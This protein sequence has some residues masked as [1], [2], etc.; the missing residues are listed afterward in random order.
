MKS[1]LFSRRAACLAAAL[2]VASA[3]LAG[4]GSSKVPAP[5][6]AHVEAVTLPDLADDRAP[7]AVD[8]Y[9]DRLDA[10]FANNQPTPAEQFTYTI[11]DGAVTITAYTG[12]DT[13]V[14][15]PETVE[16]LPVVAIAEHAFAGKGEVRGVSI[17]DSVME[18]EPGALSGCVGLTTLRTPLATASGMIHFGSLFG[19]ETYETNAAHVPA[20]LATLILTRGDEIPAYAFYDCNP[21][22]IFLPD[23]V[24][25]IGDFAFYGN[26][27]LVH[28][29][30]GETALISVGEHAFTNC[31]AL[32]SLELP[33]SVDVMGFAMLEGCGKLESL[34][35]PFVGARRGMADLPEIED[36]EDDGDGAD[37]E[38][39]LTA[40]HLGYL[41]G[42]RAYV[43][44]AGYIPASLIT[45]TVHE[46]CGEIADNAFFECASIREVILPAGVTAIGRRAFYGCSKI[47]RMI[48][49]DSVTTLGDDA[50]HGCIRL[51]ELT[52]GAGVTTL[53]VQVFMDCLSLGHVTLPASVTHLPNATFAGCI[54]LEALTAPGVTS[55]GEQV[56]RHCDKLKGWVET[57]PET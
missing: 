16:E 13:V 29:P 8:E 46:G 15:I 57:T 27:K 26:E 24:T 42:A 18:I 40:D 3:A 53:G 31:R 14:V 45:V 19:A 20:G 23:T 50:F 52:L 56:F 37:S 17:P 41:F 2:L 48:I 34:T 22:A 12:G 54:S 11:A 35:I 32:L 7:T 47:S 39:A 51:T 9:A 44:S 25:R 30:L 1:I 49:P 10:A 43:H 21:E 33:A 55:Q 5:G 38:D 36:G 6:E 28:L 4:C